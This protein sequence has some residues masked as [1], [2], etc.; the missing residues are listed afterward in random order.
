[1]G[2]ACEPKQVDTIAGN[3]FWELN[4]SIR[5]GPGSHGGVE[6]RRQE[7]DGDGMSDMGGLLSQIAQLDSRVN[8]LVSIIDAASVD[9]NSTGEIFVRTAKRWLNPGQQSERAAPSLTT[10]TAGDMG[11]IAPLNALTDAKLCEAMATKFK[12]KLAR[13]PQHVI[14][15]M[16]QLLENYVNEHKTK[17]RKT[18][19]GN[20]PSRATLGEIVKPQSER[21]GSGSDG[22]VESEDLVSFALSILSTLATSPGFKIKSSASNV[23]TSVISSLR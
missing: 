11:D 3:L 15:L 21:L 7:K 18:P 16:S 17:A 13:S 1:M 5:F 22:D 19:D 12:D 14:E 8:L 9:D 2:A 4:S 23:L 20:K 6:T 10:L